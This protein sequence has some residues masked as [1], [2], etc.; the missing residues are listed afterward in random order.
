MPILRA[1][2]FYGLVAF[3]SFGGLAVVV[4]SALPNA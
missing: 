1:I 4:M 3:V 2:V